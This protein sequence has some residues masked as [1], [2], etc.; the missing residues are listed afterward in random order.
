MSR[1]NCKYLFLLLFISLSQFAFSQDDRFGF[2]LEYA[3][4]FSQTSEEESN[5]IKIS[6]N[7]TVR[8]T[9]RATDRLHATMGFGLLNTG[10]TQFQDFANQTFQG[11]VEIKTIRTYNYLYI[12]IGVKINCSKFYVL[13][14]IGLGAMLSNKNKK[15]STRLWNNNEKIIEETSLDAEEFNAFTFPLLLSIGKDFEL[16]NY[17]VSAGVK[18]YYGLNRIAKSEESN[19]HYFGAGFLLAIQL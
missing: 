5:K 4:N 9:Y 2:F 7:Y 18:G 11:Q 19:D 8:L 12:P 13:P 6:H 10:G 17:L 1:Q 14:E 3:P 16:G 15:T